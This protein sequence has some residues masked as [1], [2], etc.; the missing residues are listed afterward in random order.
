MPL[1]QQLQ[2]MLSFLLLLLPQF[3]G[4]ALLL[5]ALALYLH[6]PEVLVKLGLPGYLIVTSLGLAEFRIALDVGALALK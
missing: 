6:I 1:S 3:K 5:L 2:V 4:N